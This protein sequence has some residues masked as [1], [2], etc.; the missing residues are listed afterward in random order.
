MKIMN[1]LRCLIGWHEYWSHADHIK[2]GD[3]TALWQKHPELK[4]SASDSGLTLMAKFRECSKL[5][6]K[7]CPYT[8]YS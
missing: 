3:A 5:R 2:D 7:F 8:Y 1:W 6:C 4:P